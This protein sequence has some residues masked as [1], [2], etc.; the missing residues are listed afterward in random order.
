MNQYTKTALERKI[1]KSKGEPHVNALFKKSSVSG[2]LQENQDNVSRSAG[3]SRS[4][5]GDKQGETSV[6]Q[7]KDQI[8]QGGMEPTIDISIKPNKIRS[9]SAVTPN[10][11]KLESRILV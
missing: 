1:S 7:Q 6:S 8:S 10:I 5:C 9:T 11:E 3:K 2:P 4:K